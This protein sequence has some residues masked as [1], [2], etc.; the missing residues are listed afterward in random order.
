MDLLQERGEI[1]TPEE[2]S[3]EPES[4]SM[5]KDTYCEC[6]ITKEGVLS[7]FVVFSVWT[8]FLRAYF[9]LIGCCLVPVTD[10]E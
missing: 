10:S 9:H 7:T 8:V 5:E 2:I 3:Q 4:S 1:N 6:P